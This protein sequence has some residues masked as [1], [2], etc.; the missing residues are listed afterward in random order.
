MEV[1]NFEAVVLLLTNEDLLSEFK[2]SGIGAMRG[3]EDGNLS[4]PVSLSTPITPSTIRLSCKFLSFV[5]SDALTSSR[6]RAKLLVDVL[7]AGSG[8]AAGLVVFTFPVW[9][10]PICESRSRTLALE[11]CP[12]V[13]TDDTVDVEAAA[14]G[15]VDDDALVATSGVDEDAV[16]SSFNG[17]VV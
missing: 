11:T 8:P 5:S 3:A 17:S 13:S 2:L 10:R 12:V 9:K 7:L 4:F 1:K 16:A 15:A 14:V 6:F